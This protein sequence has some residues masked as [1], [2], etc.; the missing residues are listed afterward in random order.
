MPCS[1]GTRKYMYDNAIYT[2]LTDARF[3]TSPLGLFDQALNLTTEELA[4]CFSSLGRGCSVLKRLSR[5]PSLLGGRK[6]RFRQFSF[7]SSG[8]AENTFLLLLFMGRCFGMDVYYS[9]IVKTC[10]GQ[11]VRRCTTVVI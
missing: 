3:I 6:L 8:P 7:G 2:S 10:H 9:V 4:P 11:S 1:S 5:V